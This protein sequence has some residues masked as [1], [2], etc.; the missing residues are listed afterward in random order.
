[1]IQT[2]EE[3]KRGDEIFYSY[4]RKC[5]TRF[6]INYGFVNCNNDGNIFQLE[7]SLSEDDKFIEIKRKIMGKKS[8][9]KFV[10]NVEVNFE[11]PVMKRFL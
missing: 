11:E 4:G 1:M 7:L 5:N 10:F 2:L 3:I 9:T 6:F 8:G